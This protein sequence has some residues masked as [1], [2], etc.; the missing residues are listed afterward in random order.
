[1]FAI[2]PIVGNFIQPG[3]DFKFQVSRHHYLNLA[4]VI[5]IKILS[6]I[7]LTMD[8]E[9]LYPWQQYEQVPLTFTYDEATQKS[10]RNVKCNMS[11]ISFHNMDPSKIYLW[12]RYIYGRNISM[13]KIYIEHKYEPWLLV[14][15]IWVTQVSTTW[16]HMLFCTLLAQWN[17][18]SARLASI[19]LSHISLESYPR[20]WIIPF[21]SHVI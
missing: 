5:S 16:M 19:F 2:Q 9:G 10:C 15:Y 18:Q 3:Q 8:R 21:R 6:S 20:N 14:C 11:T 7:Q 13:S 17:H 1:M 12:T 4:V